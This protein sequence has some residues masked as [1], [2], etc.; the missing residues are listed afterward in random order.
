MFSKKLSRRAAWAASPSTQKSEPPCVFEQVKVIPALG[1]ASVRSMG[2]CPTMIPIAEGTRTD[3][4]RIGAVF[5]GAFM[6]FQSWPKLFL[7]PVLDM[8]ERAI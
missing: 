4:V 7:I 8:H 3:R 1:T 5:V 2:S 6:S